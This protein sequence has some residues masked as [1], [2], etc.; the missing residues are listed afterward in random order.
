[1]RIAISGASGFLGS[2]LATALRKQGND[3]LA[4]VRHRPGGGEIGWDPETG[5]IEREKLEAVEAIVH[6]AGENIA[7]RWTDA[8]KR[9][10]RESRVRGTGLLASTLAGLA[11]RPRVLVSVSAV[12]IYGD[13]GDEILNEDSAPGTGFL[14]EV[15]QAWEAAAQPA[16]DAGIRVVHPRLG[17]IL[18]PDGGALA[19]M[20][21][22][23][24]LGLGGKLGSGAQWMSWVALDDVLKA[25]Q[26]IIGNPELQGPVN[27]VSP[28][29]VRNE[30]FTRVLAQELHRP[31]L[32]TV[33]KVALYLR[34]GREMVNEV[35]IASARGMPKRLP[36]TGFRFQFPALRQ[37]LAWA[38][39]T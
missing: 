23:F 25:M 35:L 16:R 18:G 26:H 34:F 38:L 37:A 8:A 1:M 31:A 28:E 21:P 20:L 3:V 15:S 22:P 9:R 24:R 33:P 27:L 7:T 29:P 14:A 13:R 17:M 10:I 2:H 4:L 30:E 19:K 6:L 5:G 36:E 12:G 32:F 39:G 11:S